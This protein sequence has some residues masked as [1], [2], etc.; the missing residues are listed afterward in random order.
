MEKGY[1][2]YDISTQEKEEMK[3][4]LKDLQSQFLYLK[5]DFDNYR[6]RAEKEKE[7]SKK[8]GKIMI[9]EKLLYFLDVFENALNMMENT[10]DEEKLIDGMKLLYKELTKMLEEEGVKTIKTIGEKFNPHLHEV[11]ETITNEEIEEDTI[12]EEIARGYVYNGEAIRPAKVKISK[13]P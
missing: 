12:V 7:T 8:I 2:I 11:I 4:R 9:I 13:K 1:P 10:K 5:A 3:H 6:K